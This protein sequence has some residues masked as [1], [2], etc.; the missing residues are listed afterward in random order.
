MRP[1]NFVKLVAQF[2]VSLDDFGVDRKGPVLELQVAPTAHVT[3]TALASDANPAEAER[4]RH[5][6]A[7]YLGKR[8]N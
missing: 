1:G 7:Q 4:Y 8:V 2:D 3:V 6:A 5:S